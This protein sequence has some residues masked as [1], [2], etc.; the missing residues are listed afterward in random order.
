MVLCWIA[1]F[2]K[3][4]RMSLDKHCSAGQPMPR[5]HQGTDIHTTTQGASSAGNIFSAA[6]DSRI[7][8]EALT[9][10]P[11]LE[12]IKACIKIQRRQHCTLMHR[13][14]SHIR[15][16]EPRGNHHFAH[17]M[18]SSMD[19]YML[20]PF[21][22]KAIKHSWHLTGTE[23]FLTLWIRSAACCPWARFTQAS[24]TGFIQPVLEYQS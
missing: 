11:K 7:P 10:V 19:T 12:N 18:L 2:S 23:L 15:L 9:T 22:A 1:R 21:T 20:L 13:F 14:C 3:P 4:S 16:R 8:F 24:C 17:L 6:A 5:P